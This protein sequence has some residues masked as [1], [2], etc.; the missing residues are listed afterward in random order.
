[1]TF[2]PHTPEDRASMTAAIGVDA[3]DDLFAVVP[4]RVRFPELRL[5]RMLTEMEAAAR[6][7]ELA[8]RNVYPKNGDTFLGAGSYHHYVPATVGQI[9]ARGEFYT[10][11]T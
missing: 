3:V 4:E 7:S 1:M 11:Y 6:L 2:N 5:P 9:L 10:A 8:E